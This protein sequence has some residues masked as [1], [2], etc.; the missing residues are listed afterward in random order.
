MVIPAI[1]PNVLDERKQGA[2]DLQQRPAGIAILDVGRV[3]FDKYRP[4]VGIDQRMALAALDLLSGIIAARPAG[5]GGLDAL[6]V[7][8]GGGGGGVT[9]D[10]LAVGDDDGVLDAFERTAIPP[11]RKSAIDR[12]SGRKVERQESDA[13][14]QHVEKGVDDLAHRPGT[15]ASRA[16]HR[17][18]KRLDHEPLLIGQVCLVARR[19]APILFAGGRGPH[20]NLQAGS[21]NSLESHALRPLNHFRNSFSAI[22]TLAPLRHSLT[23]QP[24]GG[25]ALPYRIS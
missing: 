19:A 17:W 7:D 10:P 12:A 15:R 20:G 4:S 9:A 6:A 22:Q 16:C 23:R 2:R 3:R 5:F 11:S 24:S 25:R 13:A 8:D 1:G 14:A 21:A 18:Q